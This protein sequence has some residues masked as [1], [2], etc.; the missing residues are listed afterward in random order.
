MDDL[1]E[2]IEQNRESIERELRC[3]VEINNAGALLV[4]MMP[5]LLMVSVEQN[6]GDRLGARPVMFAFN[7]KSL[8]DRAL[9]E[10]I[11]NENSSHTKFS[12]YLSLLL[13]QI[14]V[15]ASLVKTR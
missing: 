11:A 12:S 3:L 13:R 8:Y 5:Q 2:G 6:I 14:C 1:L 9:I 4:C 15:C 7:A 10:E